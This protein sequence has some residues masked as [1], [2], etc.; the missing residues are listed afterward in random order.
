[1]ILEV[2]L[3]MQR[4]IFLCETDIAGKNRYY[5]MSTLTKIFLY[6]NN[7]SFGQ[8][9]TILVIL[10]GTVFPGTFCTHLEH[11]EQ[12]SSCQGSEKSR[13]FCCSLW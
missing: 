9:E 11:G 7:R 10:T 5:N 6:N 13:L 8:H 12:T 1:M 2:V 3:Q 4:S